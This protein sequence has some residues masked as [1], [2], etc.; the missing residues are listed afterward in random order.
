[1]FLDITA[2]HEER[3][4]ILDIVAKTAEPHPKLPGTIGSVAEEIVAAGGKALAVQTD[5][6]FPEQI[7]NLAS[8]TKKAFGHADVLINNAVIFEVHP[9]LDIDY[10]KWQEMWQ[11][12]VAINLLGPANL[13]FCVA[14]HMM[15][16]GGGKI[17]NI[18]SR[19]AFRGEPDAPA[20]GATKAGLHAMSQSLAKAL[21]PHN[22]FFFVIAPGFVDTER[23][24]PFL[25]GPQGD[26]IRN[27]SPLGRVA[28][29]AEV[30]RTALFL[31][32]EGSE[33]LTGCIV[34]VNGASY[35][36][37]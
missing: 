25:D 15:Q 1:M 6:R 11:K 19:G 20:Y 26:E 24:A 29:P 18:G 36:R 9:I 23:V 14:K 12:T 28:R 2:S 34:D 33:F 37:S 3:N 16:F 7:E 22:I 27:Q 32:S 35:L 21:A 5:V 10:D 13:S 31:A 30:A 4:I 17:V 8:E